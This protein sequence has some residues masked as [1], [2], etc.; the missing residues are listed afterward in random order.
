MTPT[1]DGETTSYFEWLG[2]G[3]LEVRGAG[4]AMHQA[5][6]R[7]PI[8]KLVRFGFGDDRLYVRLDATRRLVD[9]LAEGY[10]FT[11]TFLEPA[12][13]HFTVAQTSGRLIGQLTREASQNALAAASP[14]APQLAAGT[15]IEIGIL[16]APLGLSAGDRVAF[17]V[18]VSREPG[19]DVER[20]PTDGLIEVTVPGLGFE[21]GFWTT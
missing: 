9:L 14:G 13:V 8:L 12:G 21:A 16:L 18:G 17:S 3:T 5:E 4:G 20:H 19:V 7:P 1:L 2:A 10:V 6:Q 15:R 11:L